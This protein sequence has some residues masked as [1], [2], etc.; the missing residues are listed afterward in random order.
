MDDVLEGLYSAAAGM[1]AQS[2]QLNAIGNDL[3]NA[4]T[5][6]YQAERVAFSDLLYNPVEE[7]GTVSSVGAGAGARL[8]GRSEAQGAIKTTGDP[9]DLA[10]E[11]QGYFQVT[12]AGGKT[13]L[14]RNGSFGVDA[15][16]AITDG[17]GN[18]LDPPVKIPSGVA[19]SE[20]KIASDGTVSARGRTL[21]RI[22]LVTVASPAH[23]LA[24]ANGSLEANAASGEA[25]PA[26]SARLQQGA[27]EESNVDLGREMT[28][29]VT[30]ERAFQMDS[31][32][33]QTESQMMLI[34]NQLRP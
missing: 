22:Q 27:L 3:A 33:I 24:A 30:T 10:I 1:A 20:V 8:I 12:L 14:T 31:T 2:E 15:E 16:G 19:E 13:A 29:M 17:E 4:S 7:A 9:L 18:L 5:S 11:G 23:L 6:G 26:T 28:L 32:A 34:A 25:K 21:G